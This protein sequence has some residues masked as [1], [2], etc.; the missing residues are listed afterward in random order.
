MKSLIALA[1]AVVTL[2]ATSLAQSNSEDSRDRLLL[3][4][5]GGVNYA[6]V[7]DTQG[8]KFEASPK[9][10]FVGGAFMSIPIGTYLGLQPEFLYSK[11]GFHATGQIMDNTYYLTR[12]LNYIDVPVF[13]TL[14][15]VTAITFMAGPQFSYLVKQRDRFTDANTTVQQ[16]QEFSNPNLRRNTLC[17]VGGVDFNLNE[18]VLGV[19]A[20][21]DVQ[22]NNG[23]GTSTIPRYKNVWLQA[24]FG[25]RF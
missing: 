15:P 4:L 8:E 6:N 12:T 17:F 22:H 25:F 18:K 16:E 10:G 7:Y 13:I 23:D 3:G 19:R 9:Y 24:T 21:W 20:G 14:K 11:K 5:K 2:S 1:M